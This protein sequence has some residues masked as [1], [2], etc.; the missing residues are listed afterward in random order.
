[1]LQKSVQQQKVVDKEKEVAVLSSKESKKESYTQGQST[2]TKKDEEIA[3]VNE[4]LELRDVP[5]DT[6]F[7]LDSHDDNQIS[8]DGLTKYIYF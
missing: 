6:G 8:G 5:S 7:G 4:S 3:A 2:V 1:M